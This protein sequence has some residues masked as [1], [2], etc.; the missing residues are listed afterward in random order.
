MES[1]L[2]KKIYL[3]LIYHIKDSN[4]KRWARKSINKEMLD[5]INKQKIN[6]HNNLNQRYEKTHQP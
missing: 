5:K 4:I 6:Y 1:I 2:L 3:S